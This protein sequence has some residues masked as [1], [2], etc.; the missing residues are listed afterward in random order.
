VE[1]RQK[2][3][4]PHTV[5]PAI[6][7]NPPSDFPAVSLGGHKNLTYKHSPSRILNWA[8]EYARLT[9][10][11][12]GELAPDA[13]VAQLAQRRSYAPGEEG[14]VAQA[15]R[16]TGVPR[17]Q[18]QRDIAIA[19]LT[20]DER[21]SARPEGKPA[22]R[23]FW[24]PSHSGHAIHISKMRLLRASPNSLISLNPVLDRSSGN[25]TPSRKSLILLA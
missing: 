21:A 19:S 11:K 1:Q 18:L 2:L 17:R 4:C 10:V 23:P 5:A 12:R 8:S 13:N 7:T 9:A 20:E 3:R 25:V 22:S 24:A 6:R 16:E 15:A 14:G